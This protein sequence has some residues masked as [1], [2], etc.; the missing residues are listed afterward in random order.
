MS[1]RSSAGDHHR[2]SDAGGAPLGAQFEVNSYTTGNQ[3]YP[4]VAVEA[5][6]SFVV[7]WSSYGSAGSDPSLSSIQARRYDS[8]GAAVGSRFQ[9]NSYTTDFQNRAAVGFDGAG[10][11]VVA[12]ESDGS[13]GSDASYQ[14]IQAQRYAVG[15]P[16]L[17]KKVLVKDPTGVE[18]DRGVVVL[19]KETATDIGPTILGNPPVNGATLRVISN[20]TTDSDEAYVLDAGGW[21]AGT[22]GFKYVGPTGID[23]DPVKKVIVKRTPSGKALLKALLKGNV[24]AQSL[25]VVPPN[26]GDDG[27]IILS[28][29]GGGTYCAAFGGGAGGTEAVDNGQL[30][31]V[32]NP[33]AEGCPAP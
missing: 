19:G 23:A 15:R 29:N 2:R 5:A 12:W 33:T 28:I 22:V 27:G 13:A 14:S 10:N 31:K 11:F 6:G 25:D 20:G 9:L 4:A 1:A 17:G 16:I 26:L 7:A 8:A 30:W 3:T 18:T 21:S 24:G 32:V